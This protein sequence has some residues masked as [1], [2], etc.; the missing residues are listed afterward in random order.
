[1]KNTSYVG[2]RS[3]RNGVFCAVLF[4]L[5]ALCFSCETGSDPDDTLP[6]AGPRSIQV[7]ARNE[8]LVLQWTKVAPA[9]G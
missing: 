7:T 4:A 8:S 2:N 6:L 1:M 5:A 9:R 3:V